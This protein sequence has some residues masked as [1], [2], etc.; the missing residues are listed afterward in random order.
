MV[1]AEPSCRRGDV[2]DTYTVQAT[3]VQATTVQATTVQATTVQGHPTP[4]SGI[5]GPRTST[6]RTH[7]TN[8]QMSSTN[9]Q[10]P[11]LTRKKK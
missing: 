2:M 6:Q 8:K 9:L 11:S 10:T 5:R 1:S 7:H 3:T 4:R